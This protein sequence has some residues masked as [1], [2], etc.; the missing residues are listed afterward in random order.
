MDR[1]DM[2]RRVIAR[3]AAL[4]LLWCLL[5]GAGGGVESGRPV[6]SIAGPWSAVDL[7]AR[8]AVAAGE[9]PGVVVLV[10]QGDRELYA[11]ATG[12][13][14]LVPRVEPMTLDTV[15]DVASLTK[16]VA[17]TPSILKLWEQGR[18]DL[19][20][21]LGRYLTEFVGP[22]FREVTIR[23]LLIHAS[24]LAALPRGE[25]MARRFPGAAAVQARAG[26]A[27]EPGTA[28]VYS[29]TGFIMLAEVVRRVSGQPLDR[30][31]EKHFYGPLGMR[32]TAF[33]PPASWRARIAPTESVDGGP[34]L[35]GVVHDGNARL[36]GGVAGHAGL[37][38]TA[39]DLSRFCRMLLAGGAL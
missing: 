34:P 28:F 24:G 8:D 26:L 25:A 16:V 2:M 6:D 27:T 17:T 14:A 29:D 15:F 3:I 30:Y 37:F 33:R 19:D 23:R 20:A 13:R 5:T 36:L 39:G 22:A 1:P 35:R 31:A 10:G 4:S 18:I 32:A 12:S 9:V 11:R 7:A 21:P 38:S